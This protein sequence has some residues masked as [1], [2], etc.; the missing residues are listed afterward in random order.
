MIFFN[1]NSASLMLLSCYS[2]KELQNL[3]VTS[4]L[5]KIIYSIYKQVPLVLTSPDQLS[6]L[7]RMWIKL[8][9]GCWLTG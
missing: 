4:G 9:R 8:L 6:A 7:R 5:G 1:M 2:Q 3:L